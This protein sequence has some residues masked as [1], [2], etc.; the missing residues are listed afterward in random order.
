MAAAK[1]GVAGF[2]DGLRE[3]GYDPATLRDLS[4]HVVFPYVVKSG[5]FAGTSVRLGFI[6]PNEFPDALP[7][8][9]HVS[10][11]LLPMGQSGGHPAGG[12]HHQHAMPFEQVAGGNWQYWSRPYDMTAWNSTKRTPGA[13][14][15]HIAKLWDTQ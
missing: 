3:M 14:M 1:S 9:M 10:P 12:I 5:R 6:V 15:A 4:N 11:Q 7:T 8:G 13:Y 2:M